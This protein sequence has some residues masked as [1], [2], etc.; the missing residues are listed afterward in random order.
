MN[1]HF[2]LR[3]QSKGLPTI[4]LQVFD[5]RFKGRK[6]MYSTGIKLKES[7]WDKRKGR[8]K[9]TTLNAAQLTEINKH[10]DYL[11]HTVIDFRS[12][13][14][15]SKNLSREDLK[16]FILQKKNDD[17]LQQDSKKEKEEDFYSLWIRIVETTKTSTGQVVKEA[18]KK[19]KLQTLNLIKSYARER[20]LKL[21]FDTIDMNFYHDFD[22]SMKNKGLSDNTRG[23]HFKE[24]KAVLRE[25]WDRD[26]PVNMAFQKKSF[27]VIRAGSDSTYLNS[28]EI[29]KLL[30][31]K[32]TP[33]Q[34]KLRD[35]FVM[36]CFVGARHSDWHQIR[37][38]NISV[39]N[40][41][42][43][44]LIDPRKTGEIY[45][46]PV[47]P[48]VRLILNKYLGYPPK[49]ISNQKF[50]AALK[51]IGKKAELGRI[52]IDGQ[53]VEKWS[54]LSTHCARRSFA[55]NAY[56]SRS[57]DVYQIMKCTGHKTE[58]SFLAYLKLNG[59]DYAMQAAD[60]KF[61]SQSWSELSIA[62]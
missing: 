41:K 30:L 7:D 33:A 3:R 42:E 1:I 24:L 31:L 19:T 32:L 17:Q 4:I 26:I 20:R 25:A 55:T 39:E 9:S 50:N 49:V 60:S 61:F 57:M 52:F 44:I 27:R 43:L 11:T 15:N 54:Q 58:A 56:L 36:A 40:G 21:T 8:A 28:G 48:V 53:E 51:E 13:R 38:S 37:Q 6:F 2:S 35:L 59:K 14:H 23:R 12:D 18:T 62:S 16:L 46:V 5:G 34:E 29:R 22:S 10:L 47:H 45:H